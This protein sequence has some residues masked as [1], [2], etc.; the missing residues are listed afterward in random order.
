VP[1][2]AQLNQSV[3]IKHP[4]LNHLWVQYRQ[5]EADD[6]RGTY[7]VSISTPLQHDTRRTQQSSMFIIR[8]RWR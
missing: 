4:L 3:L 6:E 2:S 1:C 8:L 7:V 5:H